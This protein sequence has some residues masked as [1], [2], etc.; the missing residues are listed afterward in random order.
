[1]LSPRLKQIDE[2]AA[3]EELRPPQVDSG[4]H[5][6]RFHR[7]GLADEFAPRRQQ[8]RSRTGY[9]RRGD[10]GTAGDQSIR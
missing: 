2:P 6:H 8:R 7:F 5:Q 9:M 1:M 10:A 3:L 4:I